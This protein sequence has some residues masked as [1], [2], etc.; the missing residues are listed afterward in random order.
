MTG[1]AA[2]CRV[3]SPQA[4]GLLIYSFH[5]SSIPDMI[6][7]TYLCAFVLFRFFVPLS[8]SQLNYDNIIHTIFLHFLHTHHHST[9]RAN[10]HKIP[11]TKNTQDGSSRRNITRRHDP[12]TNSNTKKEDGKNRGGG[13]GGK[14]AWDKLDDGSL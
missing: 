8:S 14:G 12:T 13:I 3:V 10:K 1:G 5:I 9:Q 11:E 7:L 4:S 6:F 2:G